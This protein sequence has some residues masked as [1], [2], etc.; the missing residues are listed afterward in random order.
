DLNK[1]Y[2]AAK[3]N[4]NF[5]NN[6]RFGMP[7]IQG[8][9]ALCDAEN[10]FPLAV[11]D[12]IE[13][14]IIRTGAATAVA[15]K[16]LARSDANTMTIC[17]CGNQGRVSLRAIAKVRSLKQIYAYDIDATLAER[18][19]SELSQELQIDIEPVNDLTSAV[20]HS[21]ICVTCTPSKEP[22]LNPE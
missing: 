6:A 7:R 15:A 9:I 2:F 20:K 8:V 12:S 17:G 11:M 10:G 18:F 3:L 14:S 13:I 4:G 19:A 5:Y 22:F 16:Y 21:D 1:S